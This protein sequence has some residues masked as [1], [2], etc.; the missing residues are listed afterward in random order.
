[1]YDDWN[2]RWQ[3]AVIGVADSEKVV[4]YVTDYWNNFSTETRLSFP[5]YAEHLTHKVINREKPALYT[6]I[7]VRQRD[8]KCKRF[9]VGP[10]DNC[11]KF[12]IDN[13]P[14]TFG[15]HCSDAD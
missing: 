9:R 2:V 6:N 15:V 7:R 11:L 12:G 10:H 4:K 5:Q 8:D 14:V 3:A 1:M 13:K